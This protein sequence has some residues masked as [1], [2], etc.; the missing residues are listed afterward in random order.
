MS[1]VNTER[2]DDP[3]PASLA[4]LVRN[5]LGDFH[6]ILVPL[7]LFEVAFKGLIYPL[8]LFGTVWL[9]P[10]IVATAGQGAVTNKDIAAFMLS[11]RG[12]IVGLIAGG[13]TI[14]LFLFEHLGVMFIA[15]MS[16][17]GS[18]FRVGRAS[19]TLATAA[20]R[21]LRIGFVGLA[22][23][24]VT[25]APFVLLAAIIYISFFTYH[26]IN[27]YLSD[28]PTSFYLGLGV[29]ILLLAGAIVV[30]F[31]LCVRWVFALPIVLLEGLPGQAA[32]G[33]SWRRSRGAFWRV[34]TILLGWEVIGFGMSAVLVGAFRWFSGMAL[35]A[36]G[37]HVSVV[38]PLV[39]TLLAGHGLLLAALSFVMVTIHS[40]LILRLYAEQGGTIRFAAENEPDQDPAI[41][42]E[43]HRPRI[44]RLWMVVG[45]AF[46]GFVAVVAFGATAQTDAGQRVK[47]RPTAATPAATRRIP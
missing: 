36:A 23:L 47:S 15:A 3:A 20:L 41:L 1:L 31:A 7:V 45:A 13:A 9:L 18:A 42:H 25:S 39:I 37:Y 35:D 32:L 33:E 38:I 40:L 21:V 12:L 4:T 16:G 27:F 17:Q 22:A 30:G 8:W 5:V 34:A 46:V 10:A 43:G 26:D 14:W 6:R 19:Q 2:L 44:L 29:G 11:P 28:R 24:V